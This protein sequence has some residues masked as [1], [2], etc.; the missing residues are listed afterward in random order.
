ML[1]CDLA[2][3]Q[4]SL[5]EINHP[6]NFLPNEYSVRGNVKKV[7]IYVDA[8]TNLTEGS[9]IE[10]GGK[11][12]NLKTEYFLNSNQMLS[13]EKDYS[14]RRATTSYYY[15]S[16][17]FPIGSICVEKRA[18]GKM[19]TS[20]VYFN[21]YDSKK[22]LIASISFSHNPN[23]ELSDFRTFEYP[24]P[25]TCLLKRYGS[26][27]TLSYTL[28]NT[29]D[30]DGFE[31]ISESIPIDNLE[32]SQ[33]KIVVTQVYKLINGKHYLTK[34]LQDGGH[35]QDTYEY[36]YN[37]SGQL[38]KDIE[39]HA[40]KAIGTYSYHQDYYERFEDYS[41][42]AN[43]GYMKYDKWGNV[44]FNGHLDGK[45]R[46]VKY[47]YY[48]KYKYEYDHQGNW[49]VKYEYEKPDPKI[50]ESLKKIT[51]RQIDYFDEK[52][53]PEPL[54][55]FPKY[56]ATFANNAFQTIPNIAIRKHKKEY[57]YKL[58]VKNGQ[59]GRTI[60]V[61]RAQN[62]S[63]FL[64]KLWKVRQEERGDIVGDSTSEHIVVYEKPI[65][66]EEIS[67]CMAIF[68]R[69]NDGVWEL[70]DQY[71]KII[72]K[73]G[74]NESLPEVNIK[75]KILLL[76]NEWEGTG[77]TNGSYTYRFRFQNGDFYLIGANTFQGGC[78]ENITFD[79]NLSTGKIN[80]EALYDDCS[81]EQNQKN[82]QN[83]KLT[84]FRK[85]QQLMLLKNFI[86]FNQKLSISKDKTVSY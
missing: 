42:S 33:S 44:E 55:V 29:F 2:F 78:S 57:A 80:Y 5:L 3:A 15:T 21:E 86:P 25:N 12:L 77:I 18:N 54:K 40:A 24:N 73:M 52:E 19:D 10:K 31:I 46:K 11:K 26:D 50:K 62:V 53:K 27:S 56:L 75:N 60:S 70:Y 85:P 51:V 9:I 6:Q 61:K 58:A 34:K 74:I 47:D 17:S 43:I 81:E 64:P 20:Y 65:V 45:L 83:I 59:Y 67:Y 82:P 71:F 7:V 37:P 63:D 39:E 79:Y 38:M 4:K 23:N 49:I 84:I 32:K 72:E 35:Y 13:V 41:V 16:N 68:Q 69:N 76:N 36:E 30:K 48:T 28:K 1:I 22:R 14:Y 66:D 8:K